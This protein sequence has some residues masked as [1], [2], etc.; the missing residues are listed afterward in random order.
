MAST[1]V[2]AKLPNRLQWRIWLA[3]MAAVVLTTVLV[4]VLMRHLSESQ[5]LPRYLQIRDA[6]GRVIGQTQVIPR[7]PGGNMSVLVQT[8]DGQTLEIEWLLPGSTPP[9]PLLDEDAG[10]NTSGNDSAANNNANTLH[11]LRH[12]QA[13][14]LRFGKPAPQQAE[15]SWAARIWPPRGVVGLG[16]TLALLALAIGAGAYPVTR[17]MTNRLTRLQSSVERWG[18]GQLDARAVID[19]EDEVALLA[20]RFNEAAAR[21]QALLQS[22]KSMLANTS[23]ELRTPLARLRMAVE[24]LGEKPITARNRSEIER[25]IRELDELVEEILLRSRLEAQDK[26]TNPKSKVDLLGLAAQECA[27]HGA[28]LSTDWQEVE[29][30]GY[31]KLL[32]RLLRNLL[33]NAKRYG[34]NNSRCGEEFGLSA[35]VALQAD[36]TASDVELHIS[37]DPHTGDWILDILDRGAGVPP[38]LRE[39]IFEPFFRLPT[40]AEREGGV[41]LG[42]ALVRSIAQHHGGQVQCLAREGGGACFRVTLPA[43]DSKPFLTSSAQHA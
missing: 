6:Q 37:R 11:N 35:P 16:L 39:K 3:V 26:N 9:P 10:K 38:A 24:L 41:G 5:R 23:H 31:E 17:R 7:R 34:Q 40:V 15:E 21:I 22:H 43:S 18:Q 33:Q 25:N 27:R 1:T 32:Q 4:S 8:A 28:S 13:Y 42:L 20:Q 14:A 36:K 19:G 2:S 29:I 30:M 12:R